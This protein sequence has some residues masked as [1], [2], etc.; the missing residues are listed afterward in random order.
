MSGQ[1]PVDGAMVLGPARALLDAVRAELELTEAGVPG[2]F[3]LVP[4]GPIVAFD[5]LL[6][7]ECDGLGWVRVAQVFPS[8]TFPQ[9]VGEP[10]RLS[11]VP[12][13]LTLEAGVVRCAYS[14]NDQAAPPS[15]EQLEE[16]TATLHAD[17]RALRTAVT[18]G[19][20]RTYQDAV[21]G[22]W[23]PFDVQGGAMGS[24]ISVTVPLRGCGC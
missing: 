2:R 9:P 14:L 12:W 22:A 10:T 3:G 18:C 13:A 15:V 5:N 1:E 11:S 19:L 20:A 17:G 23:V 8:V 4:G 24:A 7:D 6:E 16:N 21:L